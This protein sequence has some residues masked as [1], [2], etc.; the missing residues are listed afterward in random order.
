MQH[1]M[2]V[3][4]YTQ[5]PVDAGD[6]HILQTTVILITGKTWRPPIFQLREK[7]EDPG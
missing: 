1:V 2:G 6:I 5:I 7:P 3:N 4:L